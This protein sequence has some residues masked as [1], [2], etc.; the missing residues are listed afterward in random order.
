MTYKQEKSGRVCEHSP[1]QYHSEVELVDLQNDT[2]IP[3]T[4]CYECE[5]IVVAVPGTWNDMMSAMDRVIQSAH[6]YE[7]LKLDEP[8]DELH[9]TRSMSGGLQGK[10][11]F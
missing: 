7:S 6:Q 9:I 1:E 4:H 11:L 10:F 5:D 2:T 8:H 3:A